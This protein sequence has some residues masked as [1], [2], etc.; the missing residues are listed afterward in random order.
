MNSITL[1]AR[2]QSRTSA[3]TEEEVEEVDPW[4]A[5]GLHRRAA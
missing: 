5:A 4:R 3:N 1:T 2:G